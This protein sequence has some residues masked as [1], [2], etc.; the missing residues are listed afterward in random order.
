MHKPFTLRRLFRWVA[1][2]CVGFAIAAYGY[3]VVGRAMED[4]R[5]SSCHG[6]MFGLYCA[7]Q[8]YH[9]INGHFPP[10]YLNG[11]DGKPWHSWRVLLLPYLEEDDVFRQYRF[12]EP[13]NGP[14]NRKLANK[15]TCK[16]FQC[17]S[18]HD[19]GKTCITNFAVVVGER[20]LFPDSRTAALSDPSST[21]DRTT[22]RVGR[23]RHSLDGAARPDAG[24]IVVKRGPSALRQHAS[25]R[26]RRRTRKTGIRISFSASSHPRVGAAAHVG[27]AG[28]FHGTECQR[29]YRATGR[30]IK[31]TFG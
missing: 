1:V 28:L 4:A 25:G 17:P 6:R 2:L 20:T 22:R 21:T 8:Q 10:A 29:Y 30:R 12:D 26:R 16:T 13:W 9:G 3:R 24:N 18:G 31:R 15:I 11:P 27:L 23:F 5:A 14:N 7:L 19:Y